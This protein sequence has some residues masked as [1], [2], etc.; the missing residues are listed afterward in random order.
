MFSAASPSHYV[1]L[2]PAHHITCSLYFASAAQYS[3]FSAAL[4]HLLQ[5]IL[6]L[7]VHHTKISVVQD[8]Y[9]E[10]LF[11]EFITLQCVISVLRV[12]H[13]AI[14]FWVHIIH[15]R[16]PQYTSALVKL[17]WSKQFGK[18][19]LNVALEIILVVIY[20]DLHFFKRFAIFTTLTK[21]SPLKGTFS[22]ILIY[23]LYSFIPCEEMLHT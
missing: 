19:Y 3:L 18:T 13:I 15:V 21:K 6:L 16:V 2:P 12:S 14:S 20:H 22:Q 11:C 1:F 9:I 7:R 8:H 17:E 23:Q 5:C 10:S 4:F